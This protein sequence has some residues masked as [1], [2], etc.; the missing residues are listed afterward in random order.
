M[1]KMAGE[2]KQKMIEAMRKARKVSV[3]TDIWSSKCSTDS[4][5][6]ITAHMVNPFSKKREVYRICCRVFNIRHTGINIAKMMKNLFIE[7]GID[8]KVFFVLSDNASNMNKAV[9]DMQEMLCDD[10]GEFEEFS[11]DESEDDDCDCDSEP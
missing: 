8:R 2:V 4:F 10:A 11:E 1:N 7:F 3:T 9:L 6:G 5:I